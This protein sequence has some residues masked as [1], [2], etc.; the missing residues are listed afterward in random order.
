MR[1]LYRNIKTGAEFE[2]DCEISAPNYIKVG[3]DAPDIKKDVE[4]KLEENTEQV[5][6]S[7]PKAT[8]SAK[9]PTKRGAKK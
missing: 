5:Q 1:F 3:A 9:K 8:K 2:S 7:K 4:A 6:E